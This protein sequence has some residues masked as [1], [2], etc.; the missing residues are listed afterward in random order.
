MLCFLMREHRF[1]PTPV[2]S[3]VQ[4]VLGQLPPDT[5]TYA[6]LSS[7]AVAEHLRRQG[8]ARALLIGAEKA[9]CECHFQKCHYVA[10]ADHYGDLFKSPRTSRLLTSKILGCVSWGH[11]P[12]YTYH[13]WLFFEIQLQMAGFR[14]SQNNGGTTLPPI[15]HT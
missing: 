1:G 6:Y 4:E 9:A 2:L 14:V 13:I 5:S 10:G 11:R 8:A 15:S 7:M 3:E 12:V